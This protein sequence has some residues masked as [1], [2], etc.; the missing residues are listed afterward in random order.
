MG[1]RE[2]PTILQKEKSGSVKSDVLKVLFPGVGEVTNL[3]LLFTFLE[4]RIPYKNCLC[5]AYVFI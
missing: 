1:E 5:D 3:W 4:K 2:A